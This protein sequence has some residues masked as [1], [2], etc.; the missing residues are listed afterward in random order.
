MKQCRKL[1]LLSRTNGKPTLSCEN[2]TFCSPP[3]SP[4]KTHEAHWSIKAVGN[5]L[6]LS[7][8]FIESR[9]LGSGIS[10]IIQRHEELKEEFQ[11]SKIKLHDSYQKVKSFFLSC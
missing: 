1:P 4:L 2:Q 6:D 9:W 8:A 5:V 11:I 10:R 7:A 3:L